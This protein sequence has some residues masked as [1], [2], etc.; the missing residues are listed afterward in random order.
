MTVCSTKQNKIY[1]FICIWILRAREKKTPIIFKN[2]SF[3]V[4]TEQLFE[5]YVFD[6][7]IESLCFCAALPLWKKRI[8]MNCL[9]KCLFSL[10]NINQQCVIGCDYM[11]SISILY[12][13]M[14]TEIRLFISFS[15]FCCCFI[16]SRFHFT[17]T[18]KSMAKADRVL[19]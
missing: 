14:V 6:K 13:L 17:N 16:F 8:L 9:W 12:W 3:A 15:K 19:Q 5:F 7:I 11:G 10:L 18:L 1:L 4:W 2:Y